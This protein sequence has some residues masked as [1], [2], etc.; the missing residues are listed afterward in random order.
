MDS[1][2]LHIKVFLTSW[3]IYVTIQLINAWTILENSKIPNFTYAVSFSTLLYN[4]TICGILFVSL[5]RF[6]ALYSTNLKS[7]PI[8]KIGLY[9][10]GVLFL[11]RTIRSG[12]VFLQNTGSAVFPE[13]NMIQLA[14]IFPILIIRTILDIGSFKKV[15]ELRVRDT[16]DSS[17]LKAF[18]KIIVS[19]SLEIILSVF[20]IGI[21]GLEA[22]AYTGLKPA[23]VDWILIAWCLGALTEQKKLYQIIF[24][25]TTSSTNLTQNKSYHPTESTLK[26][27]IV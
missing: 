25:H 6:E 9:F 19:L 21:A 23:F 18:K 14:T 15:F 27:S 20:A 1:T 7:L 11:A 17:K 3:L 24:G 13:S 5:Q 10:I 26:N 2:K 16:N 4:I 12:L 8:K 22:I